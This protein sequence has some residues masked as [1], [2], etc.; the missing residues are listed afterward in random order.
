MPECYAETNAFMLLAEAATRR[1]SDCYQL[2][3]E[4][5]KRFR[6]EEGIALIGSAERYQPIT[7][8]W[9]C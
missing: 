4:R 6:R 1:A 9:A 3:L 8:R 5:D 7:R 2:W